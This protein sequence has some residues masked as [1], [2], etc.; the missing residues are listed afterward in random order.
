MPIPAESMT[1]SPNAL[2]IRP[3]NGAVTSRAA[4]NALITAL[5][6]VLLTPKCSANSGIAG[7]TTPNPTATMNATAAR[8]PTST[9]S[10]R[11]G[12]RRSTTRSCLVAQ[13][14]PTEYR[15]SARQ[16]GVGRLGHPLDVRGQLAGQ[17][18]LQAGLVQHP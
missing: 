18:L 5:A 12:P 17:H 14:A 1:R 15:R 8:A 9:G 6:S 3:A 4:A 11:S 2:T 16:P 10:S 7:A 13:T